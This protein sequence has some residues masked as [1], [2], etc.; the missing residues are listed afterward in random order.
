M[1]MMLKSRASLRLC[2][3]LELTRCPKR[4]AAPKTAS[5]CRFLDQGLLKGVASQELSASAVRLFTHCRDSSRLVAAF[6]Q[7]RFLYLLQCQ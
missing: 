7:N 2:L 1:M 5:S 4:M 3:G 6:I